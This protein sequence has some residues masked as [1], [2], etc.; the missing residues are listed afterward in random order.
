MDM[1]KPVRPVT[2]QSDSDLEKNIDVCFQT[3]KFICSH[4]ALNQEPV[5]AD[6]ELFVVGTKT[7]VSAWNFIE[8]CQ[9]ELANRKEPMTQAP[10][11]GGERRRS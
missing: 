9:K 5:N 4:L 8:E 6:N 11:L 10:M 7:I 3:I 1:S 2:E